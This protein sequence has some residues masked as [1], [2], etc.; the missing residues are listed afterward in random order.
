M[1]SSSNLGPLLLTFMK[2]QSPPSVVR[3]RKGQASIADLV[4]RSLWPL[5][6]DDN[7]LPCKSL[8]KITEDCRAALGFAVSSSTIRSTIYNHPEI[9]ERA[10]KV[11]VE[12]YYR[13]C[14]KFVKIYI[15]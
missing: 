6:G 7:E 11:G 1:L 5:D 8:A 4:V 3:G 10:E 14:K 13:L 9:F 15:E 2:I 12:A